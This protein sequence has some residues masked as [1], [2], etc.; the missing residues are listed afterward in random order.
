MPR[1]LVD[2]LLP[3]ESGSTISDT[4]ADIGIESG[5]S[6]TV[7]VEGS[8]SLLTLTNAVTI[9]DAGTGLLLIQNDA[10]V[11]AG[12]AYIA[13]HASS[14]GTVVVEGDSLLDV[15]NNM[16]IGS[17]GTLYLDDTSTVD[18]GN[19][20][21]NN[22]NIIVGG[23]TIDPVNLVI[24]KGAASRDLARRTTAV[25]SSTPEPYWPRA[26]WQS[27]PPR[28][29][30]APVSRGC[31]ISVPTRRL[32]SVLARSVVTSQ[33]ISPA[34]LA[35]SQSEASADSTRQSAISAPETRSFCRTLLSLRRTTTSPMDRWPCSVPRAMKLAC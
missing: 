21:V 35:L 6:G 28:S 9:A 3:I 33:W 7:D 30:P 24:S 14:S 23:G 1:L 4:S 19:N 12:N 32:H 26:T 5:A 15:V 17:T 13:Y 29:P 20:L 25:R 18:I 8:G 34:D 22:G 10:T 31:S 2:G 11:N 27:R 16:T